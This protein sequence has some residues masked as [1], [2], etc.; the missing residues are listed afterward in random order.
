MSTLRE[1][2]FAR[3]NFPKFAPN[4]RKFFPDKKK[5]Q[6]SLIEE[7]FL[8]FWMMNTTFIYVYFKCKTNGSEKSNL[9]QKELTF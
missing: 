3:R 8:M 6:D 1:K 5:F 2:M 4:S 9:T 7:T